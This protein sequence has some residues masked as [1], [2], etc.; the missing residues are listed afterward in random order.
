M[1]FKPYW[2]VI[3]LVT[4]LT[5]ALGSFFS[6]NGMPWY[7]AV[8]I[9]PELT[10]DK[11]AFPVAWT[12]IYVLTACAALRLWN[13]APRGDRFNAIMLFFL[14]NAFL[15]AF[16]STLFFGL[17]EIEWAFYEMIAL[18]LTVLALMALSWKHSKLAT[19]LLVP[20]AG[21]VAFATVLT[22]QILQLNR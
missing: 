7:D 18:E 2:S 13:H 14:A 4:V 10:P 1:K 20:Y 12:T 5:A 3:P 17:H 16:W 9:K 6:S 21:W 11:W 19:A 8:I 22:Y 15:N